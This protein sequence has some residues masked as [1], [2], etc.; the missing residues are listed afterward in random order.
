MLYGTT[1]YGGALSN[2]VLFSLSIAPPR[3]ALPPQDRTAEVGSIAVFDFAADSPPL[4]YQWFFAGT[5][6]LA[7]CTNAT[8]DLT[9]V[10]FS[11]SG[12]YIVVI[13]NL[14]GAVTS[15]PAMLNVI[16]AVEHR[17]LPAISLKGEA[18]SSLKLDYASKLAP[19]PDWSLLDTVSLS[20]PSQFYF[21]L[22]APMPPQR[23]YRASQT[24][25][26]NVIPS[27]NM[28]GMVPAITLTGNIGDNLRL[29]CINQFGPTDAWVTLDT[30]TL[31]NTSQLYFDVSAIGQ[32]PRLWRIVPAP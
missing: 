27:L 14:F 28:L 18:G 9:N 17:L 3:I 20:S 13:T 2:G 4:S 24:G 23:F 32:P 6:V 31:T 10:Q 5:N 25:T 12:A 19:A 7:C 26:P 30:I 15:S 29:D 8:L 16:Q 1:Q 11:N 22:T 21:D